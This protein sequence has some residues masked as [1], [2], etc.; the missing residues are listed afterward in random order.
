MPPS[1]G[2][3]PVSKVVIIFETR[4]GNTGKIA[5]A[6]AM[7]IRKSRIEVSSFNIHD[8]KIGELAEYDFIAIGGP[9]HYT[10]ASE[11]MKGFLKRLDPTDLKGKYGFA[12]DTR[13]DSFWAGSAAR[14]IESKLKAVGLRV[15]RPHSSAIVRR[16]AEDGRKS[17]EAET[18]ET[19]EQKKARRTREK[20]EKRANVSLDEGM[21]Q[22]F[23][24]IG[25]EIGEILVR[26]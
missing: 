21:E 5:Q 15:V 9:T 4:Y 2:A 8:V 23:E 1:I 16:H 13:V 19:R 17:K 10:T 7:G 26:S 20:E 22:L 24:K 11:P 18:G 14:V 12:F 3:R 6:S 25:T